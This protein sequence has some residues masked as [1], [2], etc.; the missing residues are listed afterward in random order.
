M[1]REKHANFLPDKHKFI[2]QKFHPKHPVWAFTVKSAFEVML[3]YWN[4]VA[5]L[6]AETLQ[7]QIIIANDN[8]TEC[9]LV[10]IFISKSQLEPQYS[11]V[12]SKNNLITW[13]DPTAIH[14]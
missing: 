5:G 12:Q 2:C 13:N 1:C 11:E 4:K 3:Q 9:S 7:S 14:Y 6:I 10:F 8:I